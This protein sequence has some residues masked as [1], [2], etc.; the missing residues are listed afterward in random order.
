MLLH[1]AVKRTSSPLLMITHSMYNTYLLY[2]RSKFVDVLKV[3]TDKIERRLDRKVKVV[4]SD[5]G[6]EFYVKLLQ[7]RGIFAQYYVQYSLT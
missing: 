1:K 4:R 3:F 5:R 7:I 6:G 2:E